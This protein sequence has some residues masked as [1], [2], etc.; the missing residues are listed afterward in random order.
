[1]RV[2]LVWGLAL[3]WASGTVRAD[4]PA[5]VFRAGA[6]AVDVS[7]TVFPARVNGGFL[8]A[9]AKSVLDP[10]NARC[11]V[12]DDGTT[13]LAIVVVDSCMVPREV[14]DQAKVIAS[15]RTG[16]LADR[17]LISATHTHSAPA[18]MGALGCRADTAYVASLPEKIAE[19]VALAAADLRPARIGWASVDDAEDTHCRRAGFE[20][21][22]NPSSTPSGDPR[23]GLTCTPATR[24]RTPSGHPV[25]STRNCRC[26]QCGRPPA[27]RSPCSRITRCTI[28][29]QDPSP[30]TTSDGSPALSGT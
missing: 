23:L 7:P 13:R 2:N 28:S 16:I 21:P 3:L 14:L 4:G 1:M 12:L 6:A 22:T 25:R 19:C 27:S 10:L 17:M 18:A 20:G 15:K 8:E 30:P 24:T 11:L 9:Q 5:P 29:G 26:S